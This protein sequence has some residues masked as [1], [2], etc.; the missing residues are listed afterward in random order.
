MD[1]QYIRFF[2]RLLSLGT[3][4]SRFIQVVA[5]FDI[6]FFFV[7]EQYSLAWVDHRLVPIHTLK[8]I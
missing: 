8:G 5:R 1:S 4:T 3:I 6:S 7:V 2:C